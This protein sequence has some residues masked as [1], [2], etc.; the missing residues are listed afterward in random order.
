MAK[1][2]TP[3]RLRAPSLPFSFCLSLDLWAQPP[4]ISR[5]WGREEP[6]PRRNVRGN[7]E[8]K[9]DERSEAKRKKERERTSRFLFIYTCT[10]RSWF[11]LASSSRSPFISL[12]LCGE[13]YRTPRPR[14]FSRGER[15]QLRPPPFDGK[16]SR[17]ISQRRGQA[18]RQSI[19]PLVDVYASLRANSDSR[20]QTDFP[21]SYRNIEIV[22]I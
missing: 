6:H 2:D 22:Y 17:S 20:A 21:R 12:R 7:N 13:L 19:P 14:L 18:D 1:I 3:S 8:A 15:S 11:S 9:E 16:R 4:C 10:L 5:R